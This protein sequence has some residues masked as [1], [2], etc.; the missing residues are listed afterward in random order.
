MGKVIAPLHSVQVR[1]RVGD[2]LFR[3]WRNINTV[4]SVP[5]NPGANENPNFLAWGNACAGW[6]ALTAGQIDAWREYAAETKTGGGILTATH[7]SGYMTYAMAAYL[8]GECGNSYPTDPPTEKPPLAPEISFLGDDGAGDLVVKWVVVGA[9]GWVQVK[10]VYNR[11]P[12][13]K[14]FE[15]QMCDCGV[16]EYEEGELTLTTIELGKRNRVKI[17]RI[18]DNGQAGYW[19][20]VGYDS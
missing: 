7:K 5:K 19:A 11:G 18:R 13:M 10:A 16:I 6:G 3:R 12:A 8:A 20:Y 9:E 14:I 17:R 4:S 1:G 2:L 15:Q